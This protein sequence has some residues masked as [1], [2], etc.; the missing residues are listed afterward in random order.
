MNTQQ[1]NKAADQAAADPKDLA[2]QGFFIGQHVTKAIRG[3][4][5]RQGF[6]SA[7][8]FVI[9]AGLVYGKSQEEAE[10]YL[11]GVINE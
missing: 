11:K 9:N 7:L 1:N 10:E 8:N 4:Y 6:Y 5:A 3:I 2:Q